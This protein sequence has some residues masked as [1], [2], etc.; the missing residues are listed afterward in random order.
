MSDIFQRIIDLKNKN[1]T[2]C[3]VSLVETS[4]ETPRKAGARAIIYPDNTIENTIGGG[5]IEL[6]VIK[7]A[8]QAIKSGKPFYKKYILS[9]DEIGMSCGGSMSFFYEPVFPQRQL[10]IFGGGHVG[11]AIAHVSS[12]TGWQIKVID[13]RKEVLNPNY[14]PKGVQLI[15]TH[16][17]DFIN[18]YLFTTRDWL[19]IVT[20]KH[21]YD[22]EVLE[23]LIQKKSAYLGMMGSTKKV[24]EIMENLKNKG[25]SEKALDRVYAPIGLNIGTETPGEIAI[26]IIAE[27]QAIIYGIN[28]VKSCTTLNS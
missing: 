16:Y 28:E 6:H 9:S 12:Y 27:M 25:I 14:F 22:Q 17:K 2:F 5:S 4:G 8:L 13:F 7:C 15:E 18:D 10:I 11:Q 20:P 1:K 3:I 26:A 19:V 23:L 21:K 24:A